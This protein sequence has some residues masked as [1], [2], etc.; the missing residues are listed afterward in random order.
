MVL[1]ILLSLLMLCRVDAV[2][3]LKATGHFQTYNKNS[4]AVVNLD[5]KG[6]IMSVAE[7]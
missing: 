4:R 6:K 5:L 1:Y 3:I 2:R 7:L